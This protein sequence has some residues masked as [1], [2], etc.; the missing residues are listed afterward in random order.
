[1]LAVECNNLTVARRLLESDSPPV[2]LL[3]QD[4]NCRT[5]LHHA[6]YTPKLGY[7]ENTEM[8]KILIEGDGGL[9]N[10]EDVHGKTALDYALE[11]D[12]GK[13]PALFQE[14][15]KVAINSRERPKA[16]DQALVDGCDFPAETPDFNADADAFLEKIN[17]DEN[18]KKPPSPEVDDLFGMAEWGQIIEDLTTGLH[19]DVL[20][21][22][23]GVKQS[24][25][26][27]QHFSRMQTIGHK[28]KEQFVNTRRALREGQ[29]WD[30]RHHSNKRS[31]VPPHWSI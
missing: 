28:L 20:L 6:A 24:G 16:I 1:M 26:Y 22:E 25:E 2:N 12:N 13:V 3:C 17:E 10:D 27:V 14:L 19:G 31:M 8:L 15:Q 7:W 11:R 18:S 30:T 23:V 9:L 29:R 4:N 21:S 5:V